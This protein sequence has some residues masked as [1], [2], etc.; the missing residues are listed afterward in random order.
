VIGR[1]SRAGISQLPAAA[2]ALAVVLLIACAGTM[3]YVASTLE[4][5]S[6]Q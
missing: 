5:F 4:N 2:V 3:A 1:Q 6:D